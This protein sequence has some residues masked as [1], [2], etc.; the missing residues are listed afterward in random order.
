MA[1]I[2]IP[3]DRTIQ[4]EDELV[5]GN[6]VEEGS[7]DIDDIAAYSARIHETA[8]ALGHL[9][10]HCIGTSI[11]RQASH[12]DVVPIPPNKSF[13]SILLGFDQIS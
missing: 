7:T 4:P 10:A 6:S 3:A 9:T 12:R 1:L 13:T 8:E 11:R 5:V 2:D